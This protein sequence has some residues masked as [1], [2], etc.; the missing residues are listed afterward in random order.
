MEGHPQGSKGL[1]VHF[2]TPLDTKLNFQVPK[3]FKN[4]G[5]NA[6]ELFT[7]DGRLY[8]YLPVS[9]HLGDTDSYICKARPAN[10]TKPTTTIV[11]AGK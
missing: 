8:Y 1:L 10:S 5:T 4:S 2:K 11:A 9:D 6:D 7:V 3:Y